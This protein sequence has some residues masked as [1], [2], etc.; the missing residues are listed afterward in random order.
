MLHVVYSEILY[1]KESA[2]K[3]NIITS[4]VR[5][6][7]GATAIEYGLIVALVSMAAIAAYSALGTELTNFFTSV[8]TKLAAKKVS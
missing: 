5:D 6:E 3:R 8:T 7:S 1:A 2:M 4:I